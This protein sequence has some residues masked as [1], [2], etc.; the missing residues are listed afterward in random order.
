MRLRRPDLVPLGCFLLLSGLVSADPPAV[1]ASTNQA[2]AAL[3]IPATNLPPSAVP[4]TDP[5]KAII[6]A[7]TCTQ[8][9]RSPDK[10]WVALTRDYERPTRGAIW[11][12]GETQSCLEIRQLNDA[13]D[14]FDPSFVYWEEPS[15][16][17]IE[18]TWSPDS[19]FLVVLCTGSSGH[20]PWAHPAFVLDIQDYKLHGMDPFGTVV[21]SHI[22]FTDAGELQL[23]S[24]EPSSP[25]PF[26]VDLAKHIGDLPVVLQ[27]HEQR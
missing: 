21:S 15:L 14:G 6:D 13:G 7:H 8:V 19:R 1:P 10:L 3:N 16:D 11:E 4:D 25:Q 2:P 23:R 18:I 5:V 26:Q 9:E 27:L 20:Q 12:N 24:G 22:K 17:I